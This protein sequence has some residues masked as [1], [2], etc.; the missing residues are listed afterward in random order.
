MSDVSSLMVVSQAADA[1]DE[2][3]VTALRDGAAGDARARACTALV[4]RHG[5]GL[6]AL[7]LSLLRDPAE[8]EDMTQE[9]FLRAFSN[10]DLLADPAKF[11]IWVRRITFGVC[12]DWLRAFRPQLFR[13][14]DAVIAESTQADDAS[15]DLPDDS[16]SALD[17]LE[18]AELAERVLRA[19][20]SL[21]ELY[22][23]PF[24]L[25]HV[26]GLSH[27]SV[28]A[29]LGAPEATVR[30]LVSR[31]RRKLA[32]LLATDEE[33]PPRRDATLDVLDETQRAP[34]LLHVLN[35]DSVRMTLERS[36][37]PGS[38]TVW[39]DVLHEG[40]VPPA[41][42]TS[43]WRDVRA[44]FL[45]SARMASYQEALAHYERWDE[46]MGR[47]SEF[48]EVVLWFEH[49]LFDQLLLV[50]HLDWLSRQALGRTSISLICIGEFPGVPNFSGL[51]QLTAPQLASLVGTRQRVRPAQLRLGRE[52]WAAFTAADPALLSELH[53]RLTRS[54]RARRV[55]D[56]DA[57]LLFLAGAL[58]RLLAEY[59]AVDNGLPLTERRILECLRDGPLE[60]GPL[61]VAEQRLEEGV[62]MGD[63]TFRSRIEVLAAGPVPLVTATLTPIVRD[64]PPKGTIVLTDAGR[65]VL[66]GRADWIRLCGF[67]RWI[68][69]VHLTAPA[70]GDVPWRW[71][72]ETGHLRR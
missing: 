37:V 69:G 18:Q 24:T 27:A 62:F 12:V 57:S 43:S 13:S 63:T 35:G 67:D 14:T 58:A 21:P 6:F 33:T 11:G 59:P 3:I 70:G 45:A 2:A 55:S 72:P 28:A 46:Q 20:D 4:R 36:D 38:L 25:F 54:G 51:G 48:D 10:L 8:A 9:A 1:D 23:V 65:D 47:F 16:P 39:A 34:R 50:R 56:D 60:F 26:D 19:I 41:S 15:F 17:R 61:F 5:R 7:A 32:D 29:S 42:G 31:A 30:S 71:D 52:T 53:V 49:D 66:A 22:R 68:G 64:E 40:P 44:K